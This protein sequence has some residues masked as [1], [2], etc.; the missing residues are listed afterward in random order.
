MRV[1]GGDDVV[2]KLFCRDLARNSVASLLVLDNATHHKR[3]LGSV[4]AR[5][6]IENAYLCSAAMPNLRPPLLRGSHTMLRTR[7]ETYGV[8][9][10][11]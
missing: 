8:Y 11:G 2:P 4:I 9:H 1:N 7:H 6:K 5:L 3:I 10:C